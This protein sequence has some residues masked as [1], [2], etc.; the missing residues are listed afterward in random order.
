MRALRSEGAGSVIDVHNIGENGFLFVY[1]LIKRHQSIRDQTV[2]RAEYPEETRRK[3][4]GKAP[5]SAL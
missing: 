2:L 5:S 1:K 3:P 4:G